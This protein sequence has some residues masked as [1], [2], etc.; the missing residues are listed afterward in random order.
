MFTV[1][2]LPYPELMLSLEIYFGRSYSS[3]ASR[4]SLVFPQKNTD[5]EVVKRTAVF[6]GVKTESML[7]GMFM[8]ANRQ[9]YN[10][11]VRFPALTVPIGKNLVQ[12]HNVICLTGTLGMRFN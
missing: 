1:E 9:R 8:K 5:S 7:C 6:T 11:T 10:C 4:F 2:E 12:N 3:N